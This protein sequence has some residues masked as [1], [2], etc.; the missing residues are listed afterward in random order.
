MR[1]NGGRG[2]QK[3]PKLRDVIYGQPLNYFLPDPVYRRDRLKCLL[4][5]YHLTDW[6]KFCDFAGGGVKKCPKLREVIYG[7]PLF[8]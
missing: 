2:G 3:C 4:L 5:G 1:D 8:R 6:P 7:R